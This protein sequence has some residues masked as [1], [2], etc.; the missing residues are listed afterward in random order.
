MQGSI[1]QRVWGYLQVIDFDK[2]RN[3]Q[4]MACD[5]LSTKPTWTHFSSKA[6]WRDVEDLYISTSAV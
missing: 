4:R 1:Y 5:L 3:S 6:A 2:S